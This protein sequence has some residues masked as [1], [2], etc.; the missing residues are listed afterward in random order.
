MDEEY[1]F[2]DEYLK[3]ITDL[4]VL[5]TNIQNN[6]TRQKYFFELLELRI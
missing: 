1:I 5:S 3:K 4:I 6:N 2:E